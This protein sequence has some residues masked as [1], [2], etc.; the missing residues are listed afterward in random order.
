[1]KN[2]KLKSKIVI[3]ATLILVVFMGFIMLYVVPK[4]NRLI[5]ERTVDKLVELTDVA[6]SE[7]TRQHALFT[8]GQKREEEAMKDAIE[9]VK[10]FRYS[11]DDYFWIN[12][13]D[14]LMIMH[15]TNPSLDGTNILSIQDPDGKFLFQEMVDLVKKEGKGVVPYQWPKPG[16]AEPQP[17][18]SYVTAVEGWG[19]VIGTG[20]YVDDL[21]A[22]ERQ[23]YTQV[24]IASIV[25]LLLAVGIMLII[26]VPL[27]KNLK[28]ITVQT[29]KYAEM[30]F[31]EEVAL[32]NKDELGVISKSFE[33]VRSELIDVIKNLNGVSRRVSDNS[34][35]IRVS[36]STLKESTGETSQSITDI[37]AVIEETTAAMHQI[38]ETV[39]EARDAIEVIATKA[40]DGALN[41][42]TVSDRATR[43]KADAESSEFKAKQVY[44]EVK[45]RLE[46]AIEQAKEVE[47]INTLL[48]GILNISSQTHLLALNASIEAARAGEA[49][50]GFA[51]VASEI[52]KLADD[53]TSM[54]GSIQKTVDF[55]K[56]AV[57][58]L[59]QD[60]N[61]IL[62][63]IESHVLNDY[64]KLIQIGEQYNEDASVFNDIMMEL[65][66]ISEELT[67]SMTTIATNVNSVSLASEQEAEQIDKILQMTEAVIKST[68]LLEH[69][70]QENSK[71]VENLETMISRF[72][73]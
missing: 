55:T 52:G 3:L 41:A 34:N 68:S 32:I 70:I 5:E 61:S 13:L 42:S 38:D 24:L 6:S 69:G 33:K 8:S 59:I 21:N 9:S 27:N 29:G 39:E 23:F 63:F 11:S 46:K 19:W 15:P 47:K 14:G 26:I 66:A 1:M 58:V 60:A 30:D 18:I 49:G 7:I 72:K 53:S 36:I 31:R 65:S 2:L 64:E 28:H 43:L 22:I 57:S 35:D 45:E 71:S 10:A 17:K 4:A 44:H 54:V 40:S 48:E 37:S 51:V 56:E 73:I 25:I 16:S 12:S 20:V 67:S 62:T 50:R